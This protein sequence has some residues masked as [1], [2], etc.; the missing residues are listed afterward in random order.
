MKKKRLFMF[1]PAVIFVLLLCV[2]ISQDFS[3]DD[4][5]GITGKT[6]TQNEIGTYGGMGYELWKDRPVT[7]RMTIGEA[8]T[9]NCRWSS[10]GNFNVLFRTGRKFEPRLRHERIGDISVT[11][12]AAW[13][14]SGT[15]VSYLCV[16]GWT[17]NPLIEFYII[18]S[19]GHNN[20]PPGS[21]SGAS[22]KG[23][24]EIDGGIY[25]IYTSRRV[26]QPSIEG[27]R[28]FEQYWSVRRTKRTE[29][30]ISV[31]EHLKRWESLGMNLGTLYEVAFTIEGFNSSG[32]ATVTQNT[33]TIR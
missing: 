19:W 21:W 26:N 22:R 24:L 31:S 11:Y 15:G 5:D 6:I 17:Q 20:R 33:L 23:T 32:T 29:G 9:F 18:E 13:A 1:L 25:D 30:T 8:G 12:A 16:Y 14:P 4:T 2:C 27:T 7:A 3:N 28:T 10:N